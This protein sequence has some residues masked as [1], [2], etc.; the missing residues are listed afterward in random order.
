MKTSSKNLLTWSI[1][2]I[3]FGGISSTINL[4]DTPHNPFSANHPTILNLDSLSAATDSATDAIMWSL[5]KDIDDISNH[6]SY[7]I[8][9]TIIPYGGSLYTTLGIKTQQES[10]SCAEEN[11][12]PYYYEGDTLIVVIQPGDIFMQDAKGKWHRFRVDNFYKK[13]SSPKELYDP[14]QGIK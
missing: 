2:L 12:L 6:E 7:N 11:G 4:W 9:T 3:I 14:Y 5:F 1:I 8:T 10:L 13:E